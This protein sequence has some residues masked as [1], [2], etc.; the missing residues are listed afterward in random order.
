[1]NRDKKS[2]A[3]CQKCGNL[4][5]ATKG[6]TLLM[7]WRCAMEAADRAGA[8]LQQASNEFNWPEIIRRIRRGEKITQQTLAF[9]LRISPVTL[10][11]IK[12]GRK[13]MPNEALAI[14]KGK[15]SKHIVM[16]NQGVT[17]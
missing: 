15:Y 4:E 1:M 2:K 14:V 8:R 9:A 13:P 5:E 3:V 16:K 10:S 11:H 6:P 12:K 17:V 7:C